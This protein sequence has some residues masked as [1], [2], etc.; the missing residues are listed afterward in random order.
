MYNWFD[1]LSLLR[2]V[3]ALRRDRHPTV[4]LVFLGMRNPNPGIPEMRMAT[5]TRDLADALGLT[6]EHVFFNEGWVPYEDRA[7]LSG[8][9]GR[10]AV[11]T[12]LA[13]IETH[14]SFRTR[15]LDYLWAGLP[16]VLTGGDTLADQIAAAGLGVAVPAGDPAAIAA[17]IDGL[18]ER[19]PRREAVRALGAGSSGRWPVRSWPGPRRRARRRIVCRRASQPRPRLGAAAASDPGSAPVGPGV[20][21]GSSRTVTAGRLG[22]RLPPRLRRRLAALTQGHRA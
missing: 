21:P 9:G 4:R 22:R 1:P 20:G 11:G 5:E 6:G 2:A 7:G 15:V 8:R 13:H 12:H 18:L 14:F 16:M 10:P 3:D 17:A 19:P